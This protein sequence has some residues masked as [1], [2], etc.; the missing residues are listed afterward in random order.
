LSPE[1]SP[2]HIPGATPDE[3]RRLIASLG[4]QPY[5]A[6]QILSWL[7]RR[8]ASHFDQM[9]DLPKP[10]R[11]LLAASATLLTTSVARTRQSADGTTKLL[12]RLHDGHAIESVL[13]PE[14]RRN[15]ACLSTQVGCPIRCAFCASGLHGL[16]RNLAPGEILEQALHILH[17]L[18]HDQRL[19]NIVIMGVGEPLLN[20][21]AT[22]RALLVLTA[23]WAL[24]LSPRRITLSTVGLPERIRRLAAEGPHVNL[25]IS[26]HA[27]EDLTRTRLVPRAQPIRHILAAADHYHRHTR[28]EVTIEYVLIA[29][30][31]DTNA[32]AR[33]LARLL[34][35]RPYL[36]NLIPLNPVEGL[37]WRPPEPKRLERFLRTLRSEGLRAHRRKR[38]GADI[39]SACG[40]LRHHTFPAHT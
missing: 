8:R 18:P 7:Y 36:L 5:R 11:R 40:Q 33:E 15:T 22:R 16:V 35:G 26:L 6:N 29:G 4:H 13:I 20:Y 21:P 39:E 14:P 3:V 34:R 17:H 1:T 25:A 27:P 32:D 19:T 23:P 38:R 24:G 31:N 12:I 37:P 28:R 10:L 30:V 2:L 9:T